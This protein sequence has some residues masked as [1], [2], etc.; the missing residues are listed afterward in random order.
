[1]HLLDSAARAGFTI[2]CHHHE[3]AAGFAA[4][5]Y[6]RQTGKLGCCFATG[7]P[8]GTNLLTAITG[9]YQDSIPALFVVGQCKR[10]STMLGT[11]QLGQRQVG[12][13]EVDLV[14]MIRS[15]TKYAVSFHN[16]DAT[17]EV[18]DGA[19]TRAMSNRPGPALLEIPLDVQ[20]AA[21]DA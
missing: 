2:V 20:G 13:F 18:I 15:V 17:R 1:M 6:A 4:D 19:I 3:Q 5:A 8:G 10:A 12:T 9:A 7:G 16:T 21:Y 14:P 11:A